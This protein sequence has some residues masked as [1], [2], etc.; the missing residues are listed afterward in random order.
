MGGISLTGLFF[1]RNFLRTF[2]IIPMLD[3]ILLGFV[4]PVVLSI[5][6]SFFSYQLGMRLGT[7]I[8]TLLLLTML[9]SGFA[10]L[11]KGDRAARYYLLAWFLF[12]TGS[13]LKAL[14]TNGIIQSNFITIWGQQIGSAV[15]VTLLSLAL[16]DRFNLMKIEKEA[17]QKRL[18]GVQKEYSESLEKTV[19]ERTRELT[20][21]R[22][23]LESRNKIIEY[24]LS[25]ARSIQE[26]LV[27]VEIKSKNIA[28]LYKPMVTVGGDFFDIISFANPSKTGI[29]ISDVAGHGIQAAFITS[30]IKTILLQ[31]GSKLEDPAA[32]LGHINDFF[33]S[34]KIQGFITIYYGIFDS[35]L[36]SLTFCNAGHPAPFILNETVTD[37]QAYRTIPVGIMEN[38]KL[39]SIDRPFQNRSKKIPPGSKIIFYTDGLTECAPVYN[40]ANHFE[41]QELKKVLMKHKDLPCHQFI[42]SLYNDMVKFRDEDT[43]ADD[44]CVVCL[45]TP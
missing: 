16:M 4:A 41:F 43:F 40:P 30:M 32:L 8:G 25:L 38:D 15:D 17:S 39:I 20:L 29:F 7:S 27:P 21:Q 14:Q 22:N 44:I 13:I 31:A 9:I 37:L 26:K 45:D 24:E 6:I 18:I 34:Q 11:R 3:K 12:L 33:T 5:I 19:Q 10:C 42:N 1:T 2:H 36:S 28:A 23:K 35:D